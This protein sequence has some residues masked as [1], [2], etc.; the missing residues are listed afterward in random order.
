MTRFALSYAASLFTVMVLDGLWLGLIA[1]PLYASGVG[2]LLAVKPNFVAAGAFYLV[3]SLGLWVFAVLPQTS[4]MGLSGFSG[5]A[6]RAAALGLLCY[7]TYDLTNLATLKDW[8]VTLSIIDMVWGSALS[9]TSALA[10]YW[11]LNRMPPVA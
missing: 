4:F 5:T 1:K 6:L 3:F 9:A 11:V 8:P 2:H 10:G 7:A